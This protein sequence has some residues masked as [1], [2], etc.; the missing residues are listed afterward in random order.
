VVLRAAFGL[1]LDAPQRRLFNTVAGDRAPPIRRVRELWCVIGRRGGKSR[2]AAA[3]VCY[4]ALFCKHRLARGETGMVLVLAASTAQAKIV[5]DACLGFIEASPI[6]RHEIKDT[7]RTEI[8]L[9]NGIVIATH[10]NSYKNVRGRTLAAVIFDEVSFWPDESGALSDLESYRA[11]LP[12]LL[13]TDGMLIGISTPYRKLGLLYTKH[14]DHFGHPGE[15]VLC[16]QGASQ[17]F[18]PTLADSALASQRAADTSAAIS[19]IDTRFRTDISTFLDEELIEAAIDHGRPLE[20]PPQQRFRCRC[21]VDASGGR[22]DH[23]A[24]CIGHKEG[25]RFIVDVIR[26]KAPPFDPA[27]VTREFAALAREYGVNSVIGD[28]YSGEWVR[29]AWR[30]QQM[31]YQVSDL[32]KS[33]IYL[34]CLPLFTQV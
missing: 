26:G 34:E 32:S 2:A 24:I 9:R 5:F 15:D 14:R 18:N 22:R 19:E 29:G 12:S 25:D 1:P 20:L 23:Y 28:A 6:L 27:Q 3:I 4:L 7:T 33:E 11:V 21:F 16:V 8:R 30:E 17:V 10:S 31:G 13:T